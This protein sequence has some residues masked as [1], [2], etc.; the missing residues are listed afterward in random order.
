MPDP[1]SQAQSSREDVTRYM[2]AFFANGKSLVIAFELFNFQ[3]SNEAN[4]ADRSKAR[5]KALEAKQQLD[6]LNADCTGYLMG[7]GSVRPPDQPTVDA[8]VERTKK[9]ATLLA[10]RAKFDATLTIFNDVVTAV[11]VLNGN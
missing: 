2:L 9:L 8:A 1:I 10:N 3:A 5:A 11:G 4:P 7:T 6:L